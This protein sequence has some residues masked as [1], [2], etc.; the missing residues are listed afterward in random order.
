M[1]KPQGNYYVNVCINLPFFLPLSKN[2]MLQKH[3]SFNQKP[4]CLFHSALRLTPGNALTQISCPN[5]VSLDS[6]QSEANTLIK[7]LKDSEKKVSSSSI[8]DIKGQYLND[9]KVR[10]PFPSVLLIYIYIYI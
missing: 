6:V 8:E 1:R 10:P 3:S 9:I 2:K 4:S 5:R 7:G